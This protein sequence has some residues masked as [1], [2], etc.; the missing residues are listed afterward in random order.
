[1]LYKCFNENSRWYGLPITRWMQMVFQKGNRE[2]FMS[3]YCF[4]CCSIC[5]LYL[6]KSF[7]HPILVFLQMYIKRFVSFYRPNNR[8][9]SLNREEIFEGIVSI[10]LFRFF[11]SR[12]KRTSMFFQCLS[13]F[14]RVYLGIN[15]KRGEIIW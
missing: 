10:E 11:L 5:R 8:S 6:F 7:Q 2:C 3:I 13:I 14:L 4:N 15:I 9:S 12:L 1:M